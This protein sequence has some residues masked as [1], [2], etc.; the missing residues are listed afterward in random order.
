[1][2]ALEQ[3]ALSAQRVVDVGCGSGVGGIV[4][5]KRGVGSAP[6]VLADINPRA[7][8]FARANALLAGVAA[9]QVQSDLLA[10]VSGEFDLVISNPPYLR[11]DQHRVYRDGGGQFGE[12]LAGRIV[13]QAL[14][15]LSRMPNG[16][17]LLLYTGAAI[18]DGRDT[19]MS[20]VRADLEHAGARYLYEELDP[21]VFCDELER[22]AY[23]GVERLAAV[24]LKVRVEGR[25]RD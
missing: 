13:R 23:A 14:A 12:Q 15:R 6:V 16:G 2:R 25:T 18:V 5:A 9:E 21:D 10:G 24:F 7:L 17:R 20:S 4:L 8:R 22:P 1:V 3:H 19:F 11:D